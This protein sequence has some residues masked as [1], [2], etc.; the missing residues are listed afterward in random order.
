[1]KLLK[2]CFKS[3]IGFK[4]VQ[5]MIKIEAFLTKI[6]LRF[7]IIIILIEARNICFFDNLRIIL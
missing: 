6:I 4:K 3:E 2:A 7:V 1:M 5:K